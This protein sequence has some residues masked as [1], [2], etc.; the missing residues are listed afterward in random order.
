MCEVIN[1]VGQQIEVSTNLQREG[2]APDKG[3]DITRQKEAPGLDTG[4]AESWS[5]GNDQDAALLVKIL[6]YV[7]AQVQMKHYIQF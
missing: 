2:R 4:Y 1:G 7:S 5:D 3:R 6:N